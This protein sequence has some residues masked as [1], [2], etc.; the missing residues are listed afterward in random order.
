MVKK[1]KPMPIGLQRYIISKIILK[2]GNTSIRTTVDGKND[3]DN[4]VPKG[5]SS[6]LTVDAIL[7]GL[8]SES[9]LDGNI[10]NLESEGFLLPVPG[11]E[12]YDYETKQALREQEELDEEEKQKRIEELKDFYKIKL[13]RPKRVIVDGEIHFVDD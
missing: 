4:V 9:T 3:I 12:M 8:D 6:S 2:R 1:G 10:S 5:D 11:E 7:D 13:K